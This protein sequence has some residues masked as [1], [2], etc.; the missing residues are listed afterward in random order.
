M[1]AYR[2]FSLEHYFTYTYLA[3]IVRTIALR[4]SR[5]FLGAIGRVRFPIPRSSLAFPVAHVPQLVCV[6]H[7]QARP[8]RLDGPH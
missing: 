5:A 8:S 4:A 1:V 2:F 7:Q 3:A 6:H